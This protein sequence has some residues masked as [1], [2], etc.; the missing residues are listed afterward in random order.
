MAAGNISHQWHKKTSELSVTLLS[1]P[2]GKNLDR[3]VGHAFYKIRLNKKF[4]SFL[5]ISKAAGSLWHGQVVLNNWL[6]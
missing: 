6:L 4:T 2:Q 1:P 5:Y 3:G